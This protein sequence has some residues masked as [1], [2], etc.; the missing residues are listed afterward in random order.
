MLH[1]LPELHR[2]A[3]REND[4]EDA[5]GDRCG[6]HGPEPVEE[7][8]HGER[9][10][11]KV[12][13]AARR[14]AA[15]ART[16][17]PR[18]YEAAPLHG[19]DGAVPVDWTSA[20]VLDVA[21]PD[22]ANAPEGAATF[23]PLPR[24]A[25]QPKNYAAWQKTFTT[26]LVTS[27]TLELQRHASSKLTSKPGESERDFAIRVQTAQR[28]ARDAEVDAL[29]KKYADKRARLEDQLRRSEQTVEKE[30]QQSSQQKIQTVVSIGATVMGA[31]FGR[32]TFSAGTIGRA[33]TAARGFSRSAKEAEDVRRAQENAGEAK[34]ALDALDGEIAEETRGIAARYDA[35][36]ALETVKIAPK[37]AQVSVQ[38]VALGWR[39]PDRS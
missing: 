36:V 26:W 20:D 22:L 32:K 12:R 17:F 31:L 21:P 8:G 38:C 15:R 33:T 10:D 37:R 18:A 13:A 16:A 11:G 39:A 4:D 2:R 19:G 24:A 7:R 14:E 3:E 23:A 9:Q 5:G 6:G 28:E 1:R 35:D 34:K 30:E 27:Q 25:T 29:R